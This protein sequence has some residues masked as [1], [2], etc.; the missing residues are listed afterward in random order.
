MNKSTKYIYPSIFYKLLDEGINAKIAN[1]TKNT[2][3]YDENKKFVIILEVKNSYSEIT[4]EDIESFKKSESID[5]YEINAIDHSIILKVSI[6]ESMTK[7]IDS[8]LTGNYSKFEENDKT[9]ILDYSFTY[10]EIEE[11]IRIGYIIYKNPILRKMMAKEYNISV[12]DIPKD[13]ELDSKIDIGN[14]IYVK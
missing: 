3:L 12:E 14:E 8:F 10:R 13:S 6:P 1:L 4:D 7:L 9:N 11:Y 5:S 2:Y